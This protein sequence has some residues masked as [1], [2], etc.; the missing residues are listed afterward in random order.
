MVCFQENSADIFKHTHSL[1]HVV[2]F[3]KQFGYLLDN[4]L[5]VKWN[6]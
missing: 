3:I 5:T 4:I 6:N 1:K 2:F